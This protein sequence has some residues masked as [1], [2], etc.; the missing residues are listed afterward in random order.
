MWTTPAS[1]LTDKTLAGNNHQS[2]LMFITNDNSVNER[3]LESTNAMVRHVDYHLLIQLH[4]YVSNKSFSL[5]V[6]LPNLYTEF[7]ER[8]IFKKK[9]N[10]FSD[11]STS[12]AWAKGFRPLL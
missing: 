9:K 11:Q 2:G 8:L 7:A 1:V 6:L 12:A 3:H 10:C 4:P 5:K